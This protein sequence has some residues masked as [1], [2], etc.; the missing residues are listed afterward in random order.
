M[1]GSLADFYKEKGPLNETLTRRYTRQILQG[2]EYLHQLDI[3]HRDIKG[4]NIM[5]NT[6]GHVKLADFGSAKKIFSETSEKNRTS[7]LYGTAPWAA[8]EVLRSEP[9]KSQSDIWSVS[10]CMQDLSGTYSGKFWWGFLIWWFGRIGS[11]YRQMK[12]SPSRFKCMCAY[13]KF[14]FHQYH[15][16]AISLFHTGCDWK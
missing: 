1:Q 4:S 11:N 16:R 15:L 12:N 8:P 13:A 7:Y 10:S 2:V 9:A 14:K 3:I 6:R 5:R